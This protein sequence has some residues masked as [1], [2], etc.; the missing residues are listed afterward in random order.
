MSHLTHPSVYPFAIL[1][2]PFLFQPCHIPG[3]PGDTF[4]KLCP[5]QPTP[6]TF[7]LSHREHC[8]ACWVPP[9]GQF[10]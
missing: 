7:F 1:R 4:P 2:Y 5:D 6:H 9:V 10:P 8:L 3:A